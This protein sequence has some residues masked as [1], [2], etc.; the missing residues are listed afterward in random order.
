MEAVLLFHRLRERTR[1]SI[2]DRVSQRYL[3]IRKTTERRKETM[4][5]VTLGVKVKEGGECW[6]RNYRRKGKPWEVGTVKIVTGTIY[7]DNSY[8][9]SY[10]VKLVRVSEPRRRNSHKINDLWL[11]VGNRDIEPFQPEVQ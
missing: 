6:V 9:L 10:Y 7:K 3:F 1:C 5:E 4:Q 2:L 8:R 11:T